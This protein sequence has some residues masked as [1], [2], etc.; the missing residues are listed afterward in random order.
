MRN[1]K[2]LPKKHKYHSYVLNRLVSSL[3]TFTVIYR[4][5]IDY[6]DYRA[7]KVTFTQ[8]RSGQEPVTANLR[9]LIRYQEFRIRDE[10]MNYVY[11]RYRVLE[12]M[13]FSVNFEYC[14]D[15]RDRLW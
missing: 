2:Q 5:N 7:L 9:N 11:A 10:E 15:M 4:N 6:I 8:T 13:V 3:N 14:T 12:T 1:I